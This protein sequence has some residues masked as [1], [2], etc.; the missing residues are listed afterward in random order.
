MTQGDINQLEIELNALR[1]A[2]SQNEDEH[3]RL[4]DRAHEIIKL[5]KGI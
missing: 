1:E 3:K 5:L 4:L 2:I